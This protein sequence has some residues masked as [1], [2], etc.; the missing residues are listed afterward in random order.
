MA[1]TVAL[2]PTSVS[3]T[4]PENAD[5]AVSIALPGGPPRQR[6]DFDDVRQLVNLKWDAAGTDYPALM[7]DLRLARNDDAHIYLTHGSE[8]YGEYVCRIIPGT[9]KM[10]STS[11][12]LYHVTATVE[13]RGLVT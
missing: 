7:T 13:V 4:S 12:N 1:S 2:H 10:T 5:I 3:F 8:G 9:V 11:G 6:R